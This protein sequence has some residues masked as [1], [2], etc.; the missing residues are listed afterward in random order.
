MA[1]VSNM[2]SENMEICVVEA[3]VATGFENVARAEAEE[4]LGASA[5]ECHKGRIRI[6]CPINRVEKVIVFHLNRC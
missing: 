2:D 4:K 5:K 1:D 3:T 6:E